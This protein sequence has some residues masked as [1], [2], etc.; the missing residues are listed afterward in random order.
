VNLI[1]AHSL[2]G[3]ALTRLFNAGFSGYRFPMQLTEEA[4]CDHVALYDIDLDISQVV[5]GDDGPIAFALVGRRGTTGWIGG[6]GTTPSHRR[7]GMGEAALLASIEAARARGCTEIGLEVLD[8]NDA[9]LR[10][11]RKLGF[12]IVRDLAIWSLPP[13]GKQPQTVSATSGISGGQ[14]WIASHRQS[15]E[16]WQ[17]ADDT[18]AALQ[19]RG[20]SLRGLVVERRGGQVGA[21]IIR[22]QSEVVA[23]I[24]IAV[25]DEDAA[26][27][28]LLGA[29]GADRTLRLA[30]VPIDEPASRAIKQL[31][32][33]SVAVQHEM[34]LSAS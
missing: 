9:A 4:F 31:G 32:A 28:I 14:G 12:E 7:L 2:G 1:P 8:T 10:L 33:E 13:T 11:Y 24:Q 16:P 21:A 30:N 29:A 6:M 34:V 25:E 20:A 5:L 18:V 27:N 22:E 17:R 15:P 26:T 3:P 23:V 19:R